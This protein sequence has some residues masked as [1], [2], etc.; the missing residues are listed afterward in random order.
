MATYD[1]DTTIHLSGRRSGFR[2]WSW[3]ALV[4]VLLSAAPTGELTRTRLVGSAFDPA[5][6]SL[7]LSPK[8]PKAKALVQ[9]AKRPD[10]GRNLDAG[11]S[12]VA[13]RDELFGSR[14]ASADRARPLG[15]DAAPFPSRPLTRAH[16]PRAPPAA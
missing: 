9:A 16:G 8:L 5:T 12:L 13:S 4:V 2:L 3:L 10:P 14:L 11:L 7:A 6:A 1:P 15:R